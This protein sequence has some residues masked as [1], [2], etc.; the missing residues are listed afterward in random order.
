VDGP[1]VDKGPGGGRDDEDHKEAVTRLRDTGG[2]GG[3]V[4][5]RTQK[6]ERSRSSTA[7]T[8]PLAVQSSSTA[9]RRAEESRGESREEKAEERAEERAERREQR[10][11][12]RG[13][14]REEKAEERA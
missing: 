1:P 3:R 6:E 12:Q 2:P 8:E 7:A 11:E 4:T 5:T 14:S 10:R 9:E 13:E